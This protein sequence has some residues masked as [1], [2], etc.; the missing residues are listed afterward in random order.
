MSKK[1]KT[2]KLTVSKEN[3][4]DNREQN[5]PENSN[6]PSRQ[7]ISGKN[8]VNIISITLG[9][10]IV[11]L[12]WGMIDSLN[13]GTFSLLLVFTPLISGF[14]LASLSRM[15]KLSG[16]F[17]FYKYI[18]I[19]LLFIPAVVVS[20]TS[21]TDGFMLTFLYAFC[22]ACILAGIVPIIFQGIK[23]GQAVYAA[24]IVF[25]AS[26]LFI[27]LIKSQTA[28]P[29]VKTV[30]WQGVYPFGTVFDTEQNYVWIFG[31][32]RLG[33]SLSTRN[34][35]LRFKVLKK[36]HPHIFLKQ[37]TQTEATY[38]GHRRK[39][40]V[41]DEPSEDTEKT[42]ESGEIFVTEAGH[43][44]WTADRNGKSVAVSALGENA[45][46]NSIFIVNL[47]D[48]TRTDIAEKTDIQF[49]IPYKSRTFPGYTTWSPDDTS[50][51]LF[52]GNREKGYRVLVADTTRKTLTEVNLDNVISAFWTT[53]GELI[54]ITSVSSNE[55]SNENSSS[56]ETDETKPDNGEEVFDTQIDNYAFYRWEPSTGQ[57]EEVLR[58]NAE[59]PGSLITLKI[60]PRS[61][62]VLAFNGKELTLYKDGVYSHSSSFTYMPETDSS[63]I[64]PDGRFLLFQNRDAGS[65][66]ST[67]KLVN[68]ETME[69][70]E[71]ERTADSVKHVTFSQDG[72][73]ILYNSCHTRGLWMSTSVFKVYKADEQKLYSIL[74]PIATG[75]YRSADVYPGKYLYAFPAD[76]HTN[77]VFIEQAIYREG[78]GFI[79]DAI[80]MKMVFPPKFQVEPAV[81]PEKEA[82]T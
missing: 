70:T 45:E 15:L 34:Q 40:K 24:G 71:V 28:V 67:V 43:F 23:P 58:Q 25:F 39:D 31:D 57:T 11:F 46:N 44:S 81:M 48:A 36:E 16:Y 32:T 41:K 7:F 53:G 56:E 47:E 35:P 49:T 69:I 19:V 80:I 22:A 60:H 76:P 9:F 68:L 18:S 77:E 54:V 82:E 5:V 55:S 2:D 26:A 38:R 42:D 74:P 78:F 21:V 63:G 6:E 51:F 4:A 12:V 30:Q 64:S 10:L 17:I 13:R 73:T 66:L 3:T 27:L 20:T 61:G 14:I 75:S 33:N 8:M 79:K 59:S 37:K 65:K 72:K 50:F 29:N 1:K 62:Q 52:S